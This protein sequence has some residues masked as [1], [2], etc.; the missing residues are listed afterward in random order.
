MLLHAT[1]LCLLFSDR[2][3]ISRGILNLV[4]DDEDEEQVLSKMSDDDVVFCQDEWVSFLLSYSVGRL[5]LP[6]S[7][8]KEKVMKLSVDNTQLDVGWN[9]IQLQPRKVC[10]S[11]DTLILDRTAREA[12]E[13]PISLTDSRRQLKTGDKRRTSRIHNV[14]ASLEVLLSSPLSI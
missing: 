2:E 13:V 10:Y 7:M 12:A 9:A 5:G 11:K 8:D 14:F 4:E 3:L 6:R 1:P